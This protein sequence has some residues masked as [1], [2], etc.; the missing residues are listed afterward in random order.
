M[1]PLAHV[2]LLDLGFVALAFTLGAALGYLVALRRLAARHP[3][4]PAW[5]WPGSDAQG[6]RGHGPS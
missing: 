6:P 5:R 2:T 3:A 4:A 1:L